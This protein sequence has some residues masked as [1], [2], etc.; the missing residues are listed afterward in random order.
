[1]KILWAPIIDSV[2]IKKIGRRKTWLIPSQ[3]L[4]GL[5]MLYLAQKVDGWFGEDSTQKPQVLLITIV[6]FLLWFLTATQDIAVDGWAITMLLRRNV[7]YAATVNCLGQSFGALLGFIVFLTLESKDFCNKYIFNEPQDE[8]LVKLSGFLT[9]WGFTFLTITVGVALFKREIYDNEDELKSHPDFG[10]KRAYPVLWKIVK[11]KPILLVAS[12]LSTSDIPS[13]AV[14]V[15]AHLK[16]IDYGIPKDTIALFNIPSFVVQLVLPVVISKYS[17]GPRPLKFYLKAFPCRLVFSA[18]IAIFVF[19]TP[20]ML[21]GSFKNIPM[22][23]YSGIMV[24][25]F[26]YQV[27]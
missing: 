6:F 21:K 10:I 9:F 20:W 1:V 11:L 2:Y 16:L 17:A 5:S 12:I 27:F 24:I 25:F 8:G 23:Y 7:G 14:D 26:C 15:I 4:I 3:I 13:A 22:T 19:A 18:I